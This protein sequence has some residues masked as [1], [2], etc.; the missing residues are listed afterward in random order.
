MDRSIKRKR[1]HT[2]KSLSAKVQAAGG[3]S[4]LALEIDPTDESAVKE[5]HHD[6]SGLYGS[7]KLTTNPSSSS[8]KQSFYARNNG[9]NNHSSAKSTVS[10]KSRFSR[11]STR[12]LVPGHN[13]MAAVHIVCAISEN[14]ARETCVA[15]MDA[16]SPVSIF[17][18]KQGNGQT[19]AETVAY[20]EILKPDEILLNDGRRHSQLARKIMEQFNVSSVAIDNPMNEH[21]QQVN[22]NKDDPNS[23]YGELDGSTVVKFISRACF[24]QTKGAELLMRIA[25]EDTYDPTDRKSVV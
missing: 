16:G 20:L 14:L 18:T 23:R 8:R 15:S 13:S 22:Q 19:Y 25:R 4:G 2:V 10:Y 21:V 7:R 6:I 1:S 3:G 24:D 17:V 12:P 5:T 9:D 11:I